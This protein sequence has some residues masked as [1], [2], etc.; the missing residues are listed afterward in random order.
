ME[1]A[2]FEHDVGAS[3]NINEAVISAAQYLDKHAGP[4]GRRAVLILTDNLSTSTMVPDE[5][6]IRELT[7]ADTVCNAMVVGRGIRPR[8]P[9]PSEYRIPASLTHPHLR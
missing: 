8:P 4:V 1:K 7:E 3:T 9:T 2:I 6:V 5:K